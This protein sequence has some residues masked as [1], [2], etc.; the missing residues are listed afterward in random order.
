MGNSL[1]QLKDNAFWLHDF[2]LEPTIFFVSK[3]LSEKI[4][5]QEIDKDHIEW[6]RAYN[7]QLKNLFMGASDGALVLKL[8]LLNENEYRLSVIRSILH[9]IFALLNAVDT[10][11][12]REQ[13]AKI[14]KFPF[15][16]YANWESPINTKT[17][18]KKIEELIQFIS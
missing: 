9:S 5:R 10:D 6:F 3:L 15:G 4:D 12:S 7:E 14:G 2:Y 8:D 16:H 1:L 11:I 18:A 13:F 17:L